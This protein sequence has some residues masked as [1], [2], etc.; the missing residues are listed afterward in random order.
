MV[1][2]L[3]SPYEEI[4]IIFK[5]LIIFVVLQ[6][7]NHSELKSFS[8]MPILHDQFF[9]QFFISIMSDRSGCEISM[10]LRK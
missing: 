5:K 1:F 4:N 2:W 10:Q 3:V 8:L 6:L 7:D 9:N